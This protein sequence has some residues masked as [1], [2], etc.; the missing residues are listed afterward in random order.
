MSM[1]KAAGGDEFGDHQP[2]WYMLETDTQGGLADKKGHGHPN[3]RNFR[4][5]QME[6]QLTTVQFKVYFVTSVS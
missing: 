3:Q 1:A 2:E 4:N 6:G 5:I